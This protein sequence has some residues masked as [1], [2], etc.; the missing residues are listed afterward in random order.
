MF[1]RIKTAKEYHDSLITEVT[2]VQ[3][4]DLEL[5][6]QLDTHWNSCGAGTSILRFINV[7]N[8]PEIDAALKA[9]AENRTHQRWIAEIV[10]FRRHDKTRYILDT[11]PNPSLIIDCSSF[12]E[13]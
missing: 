10:A 7:K 12:I 13:I 5:A 3:P 6:I 2:W 9:I 1:Q 8:K 11:T 4:S